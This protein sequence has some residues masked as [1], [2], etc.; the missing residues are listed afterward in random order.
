MTPTWQ[1]LRNLHSRLWESTSQSRARIAR[2]P[3]ELELLESRVVPAAIRYPD[4]S[5]ADLHPGTPTSGQLVG[6]S[7]FRGDVSGYYFTNPG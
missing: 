1:T 7:A 2:K 5:L 3:L 4:F 6:P